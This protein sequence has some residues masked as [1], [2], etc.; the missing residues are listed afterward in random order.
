M[1]Q[2]AL[3]DRMVDIYMDYFDFDTEIKIVQAQS[4]IS[5]QEAKKV[6]K[7]VRKIRENMPAP[8][9]PGTRAEIMI[10]KGLKAM[11][12]CTKGDIE[13]LYIDVLATKIGS[14]NENSQQCN[15]IKEVVRGTYSLTDIGG[16]KATILEVQPLILH[17]LT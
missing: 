9:K 2:D 3:L 15:L 1:K 17:S 11:E 12:S 7:A 10:S 8:R 13:Q 6:V 4:H 16:I 14:P 5:L